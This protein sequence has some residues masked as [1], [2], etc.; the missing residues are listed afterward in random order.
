MELLETNTNSGLLKVEEKL[1]GMLGTRRAGT[2]K[3][4]WKVSVEF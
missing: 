3:I 4:F 2:S 1:V